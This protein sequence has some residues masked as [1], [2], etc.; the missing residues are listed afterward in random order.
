MN[1]RHGFPDAQFN[2][3]LL[4]MMIN[5]G[6]ALDGCGAAGPPPAVYILGSVAARVAYDRPDAG[7]SVVVV[8]PVLLPEYLDSTDLLIRRGNQVV[9]SG[10]GRWGERLSVG[11]TRALAGALSTR[12]PHMIV[13]L[14]PPIERP[15]L[16]ILVDIETFEPQEDGTVVLVGH[17]SIAGGGTGR[18]RVSKRI[19]LV[20]T[21]TSPDEAAEVAAMTRA[22]DD[23]ATRISAGMSSITLPSDSSQ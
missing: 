8:Q 14:V 15:A 4:I 20:E 10:T 2:A 11:V 1:Q 16:Q 17:W 12:M 6:L 19:S 23:L 13:T 18:E 9:A 21:V 5:L 22:V 7:R 3:A